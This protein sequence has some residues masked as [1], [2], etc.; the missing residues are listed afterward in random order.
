MPIWDKIFN[1]VGKETDKVFAESLAR[2]E[3]S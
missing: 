1:H 3:Q 2:K